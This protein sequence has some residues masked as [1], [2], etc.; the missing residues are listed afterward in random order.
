MITINIRQ[1]R[2]Q[3]KLTLKDLAK[4]SGVSKSHISAIETGAKMPTID[5]VCKLAKALKC[6]PEDLF[7]CE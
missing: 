1:I 2:K 3:Q 7:F 4:L 6:K 5:V